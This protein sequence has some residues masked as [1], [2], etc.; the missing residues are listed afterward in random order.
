MC[1]YEEEEK[2]EEKE[3]MDGKE[4]DKEKKE[5]GKEKEEEEQKASRACS[6]KTVVTLLARQGLV[7]RKQWDT[8]F[9]KGRL[10]SI[11]NVE[12]S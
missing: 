12:G 8:P 6:E 5:E 3:K 1:V 9:H 7:T 11:N 2:E 10:S 4:K